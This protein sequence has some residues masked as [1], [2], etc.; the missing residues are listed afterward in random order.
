MGLM[1]QAL[2]E[3]AGGGQWAKF[4]N[5]GDSVQGEIVSMAVRQ[6]SD[7]IT[8]LPAVS[9]TGKPKMQLVIGVQAMPPTADDDGVRLVDVNL[10]GIQRD[11]LDAAV[12]AFGRAGEVGDLIRIEYLGMQKPAYTSSLAHAYRYALKAGTSPMP[13]APEPDAWAP[14]APSTAQYGD[15]TPF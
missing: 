3:S 5:P 9:N 8:K 4:E 11:A 7:F 12:Q 6:A 1:E 14:A 13:A 15:D 2:A 10:W